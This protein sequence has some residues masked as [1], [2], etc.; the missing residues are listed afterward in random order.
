MNNWK[1][2]IQQLEE[3]VRTASNETNGFA[4]RCGLYAASRTLLS[5]IRKH[6]IAE[7]GDI[8]GYTSEKISKSEQHIGA[9]L[10]FD[11]DI[12]CDAQQHAVWAYGALSTLKSLLN[13]RFPDDD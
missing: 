13:E 10:G 5:D 9:I 1:L 7:I 11:I 12:D 4:E 3:I 2:A 6:C 8:D